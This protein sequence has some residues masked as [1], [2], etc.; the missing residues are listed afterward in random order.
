MQ[1][2]ASSHMNYIHLLCVSIHNDCCKG[3]GDDCCKGRG[4]DCCK[5]RGYCNPLGAFIVSTIQLIEVSTH[6]V[7]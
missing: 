7:V 3:R 2:L 1:L 4:V 6:Q 5:G